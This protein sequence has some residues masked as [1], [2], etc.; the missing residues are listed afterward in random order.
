MFSLIHTCQESIPLGR[1]EFALNSGSPA[2]GEA[3]P[4]WYPGSVTG[5]QSVTQLLAAER[6][7]TLERLS[8]L[9]RDRAAIIESSD[10][11]GT[12]DERRAPG[13]PASDHPVPRLR[14]RPLIRAT[15]RGNSG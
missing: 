4:A 11:A 10:P 13:C 7:A 15:H 5:K 14:H 1:G 12:D 2:V 6:A 9:E 3:R 8:G